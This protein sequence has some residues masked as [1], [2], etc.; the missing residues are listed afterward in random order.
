MTLSGN[1]DGKI[2]REAARAARAER[3]ARSATKRPWQFPLIV[4]IAVAFLVVAVVWST[5]L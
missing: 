2:R 5:F 4:A 1:S 3:E